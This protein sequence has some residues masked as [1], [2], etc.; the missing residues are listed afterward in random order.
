MRIYVLEDEQRAG[1]K[2]LDLIQK[3]IPDAQVEWGRSI[4]DGLTFL[5][6]EPP[7]DLIFSDIELLD[8]NVFQLYQEITPACPIIFCTAYNT[9]YTHAFQ[10]NGIAYLLKPYGEEDFQKAWQKYQ[11]L[12]KKEAP[13]FDLQKLL[14]QL[15]ASKP[16]KTYKNTFPVKKKE[17][18]FLLKTSK[19]SLFQSQSDFTL[20]FDTQGK[21]HI[22]NYTLT[23]LENSLDP[24]LFFRINRSEIIRFERIVS[25]S[26]YIK[27]RLAIQLQ[28]PGMEVYTSNS[29]SAAFREWLDR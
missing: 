16:V 7:I 14:S 21:R 11:H 12:F 22:L 28:Q 29:R 4:K 18:V 13:N 9:Y 10:T 27:N 19:I 20:A 5:R 25:F 8:G 23:E 2:L 15:D 1:E 17:G 26:S 6:T 3:F 24:E